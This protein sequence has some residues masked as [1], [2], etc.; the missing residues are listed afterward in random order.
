LYAQIEIAGMRVDYYGK[1]GNTVYLFLSEA[2]KEIYTVDAIMANRMGIFHHRTE[3][4]Q[5][6]C[7]QAIIRA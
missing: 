5:W 4:I 1:L 2:P 6:W 3:I 7:Q